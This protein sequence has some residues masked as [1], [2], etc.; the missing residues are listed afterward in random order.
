MS[1]TWSL[2]NINNAVKMWKDD[3]SMATIAGELGTTRGSVAGL[4]SRNRKLF[5]RKETQKETIHKITRK[6]NQGRKEVEYIEPKLDKFEVSRL[7]GVSLVDNNGCMYPLTES[8]PHMFCGCDRVELGSYCEYHAE[9]CS[10]GITGESRW[11]KKLV[12]GVK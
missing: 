1:F 11:Y 2:K 7:P 10:N 3:K 8:S 4:I 5:Q 12:K 6:L 9:K